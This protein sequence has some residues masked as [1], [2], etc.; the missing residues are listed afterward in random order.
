LKVAESFRETC[1]KN[2]VLFIIGEYVDIALAVNADGVTLDADSLPVPVVRGLLRVDQLIGY[3]PR[4]FEE[5]IG[6]REAGVDYLISPKYQRQ[7]LIALAGIT[8]VIPA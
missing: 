6:V 2:D 5:G 1:H 8:V 4:S 3:A 7:K